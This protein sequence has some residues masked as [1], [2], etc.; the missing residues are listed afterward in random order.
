MPVITYLIKMSVISS[1][2]ALVNSVLNTCRKK[3]TLGLSSSLNSITWQSERE[4][5]TLIQVFQTGLLS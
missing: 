4:R 5:I 1:S 2:S 3:R